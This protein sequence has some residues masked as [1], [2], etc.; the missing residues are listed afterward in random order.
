MIVF[1]YMFVYK[2]FFIFT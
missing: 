2:G 1:L